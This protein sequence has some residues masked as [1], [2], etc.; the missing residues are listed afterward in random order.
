MDLNDLNPRVSQAIGIGL[1]IF[2]LIALS[3]G[4]SLGGL[5]LI[6]AGFYFLREY[7]KAQQEAEVGSAYEYDRRHY[8]APVRRQPETQI[9]THALKAVANAG[10]DPEAISV[11][12]V[13]IGLLVYKDHEEPIVHRTQA[14][15]RDVDFVQPYV[16]LRLPQKAT[17]LVRFEIIDRDGEYVFIY[18]DHHD[19]KRGRNLLTPTTRLPIHDAYPLDGEWEL[20]ISAD[21]VLL[22]VHQFGWQE[23]ADDT[24]RRHMREDGEI[25]N[26]LRAALAENR[27]P[28]LSLDELLAMQEEDAETYR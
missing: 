5:L 27:L 16:Q 10:L 14:I 23:P 25:N 28:E 19:F 22:A 21:G 26:E 13:D 4:G 18:E 7:R 12:P 17:G 24:I 3:N 11:L 20:R 1:L 15:D 9:Y 2:G 8:E 6:A